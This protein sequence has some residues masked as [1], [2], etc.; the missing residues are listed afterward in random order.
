[1]VVFDDL[2]HLMSM[3]QTRAEFLGTLIR[4]ME[5]ARAAEDPKTALILRAK[6]A[7]QTATSRGPGNTRVTTNLPVRAYLEVVA[8]KLTGSRNSDQKLLTD[9][10][11]EHRTL[12]QALLKQTTI[13]P[14]KPT[15]KN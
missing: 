1:M 7:P 4:E 13:P 15:A 6:R 8:A 9:Q 11:S 14:P 12:Q 10:I 3:R 2:T 5:S